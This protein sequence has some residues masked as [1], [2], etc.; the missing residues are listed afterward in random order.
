MPL[1]V[2]SG[3][4]PMVEVPEVLVTV[5]VTVPV[6]MLRPPLAVTVRTMGSP[7]PAMTKLEAMESEVGS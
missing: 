4:V 1:T 6:G 3:A 7:T 5:K 2:F